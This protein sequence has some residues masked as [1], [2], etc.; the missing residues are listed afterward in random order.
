MKIYIHDLADGLHEFSTETTVQD[1]QI[2]NKEYYPDKIYLDIIVDKIQN[3]FR[4]QIRIK[5][6]V[7]YLCDRCLNEFNADYEEQTEQIYQIGHSDL[8]EDDEIEIVPEGTKEIDITKA[9]QD[10]F[11]LNR[12]IKL[13]CRPD[14]KGLCTKCGADLNVQKCDCVFGEIDPRLQKLK[15]FL[16]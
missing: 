13:L 4:F 14:C 9:I 3:V 5:S 16:K 7:H 8:D 2:E 1:L 11:I 10:A 12:P 6:I 15:M